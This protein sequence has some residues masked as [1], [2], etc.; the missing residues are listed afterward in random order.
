MEELVKRIAQAIVDSPEQVSVKKSEGDRTVAFELTVAKE[1]IGKIIGKHGRNIDAIRSI[2]SAA[3]AKIKKRCIFELIE[4]DRPKTSETGSHRPPEDWNQ[5]NS[6]LKKGVVT[7]FDG[8]KGYGFIT[9]E[10]GG[11]IF[12]HHSSVKA[13]ETISEGDQVT[14]EVIRGDKGLKA[15]HVSKSINGLDLETGT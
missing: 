7:W 1:D 12:V 13:S 3:S 6:E 5:K 11:D 4:E 10:E 14:F 2:L 9:M 8:R 15:I